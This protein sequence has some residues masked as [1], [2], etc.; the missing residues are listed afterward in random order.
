MI[1]MPPLAEQNRIVAKVDALMALCDQL[2]TNI[3]TKD[4]TASRYAE[5]VVQELAA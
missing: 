4:E 5:A 2:E 3:R 1:P